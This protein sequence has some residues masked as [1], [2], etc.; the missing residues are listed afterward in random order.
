MNL[1]LTYILLS[2]HY[3]GFI[4]GSPGDGRPQLLSFQRNFKQ[5][6]LLS[7]VSIFICCLFFFCC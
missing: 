7:V 3:S 1:K 6:A 5:G 2:H 4:N